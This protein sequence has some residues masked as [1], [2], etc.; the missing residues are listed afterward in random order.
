MMFFQDGYSNPL[1][2]S[3]N[4]IEFL[5]EPFDSGYILFWSLEDKPLGAYADMDMYMYMVRGIDIST[6]GYFRNDIGNYQV[7]PVD[8][9]A[10]LAV[11]SVVWIKPFGGTAPVWTHKKQLVRFPG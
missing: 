5:V 11:K 3:W 8:Q 4:P 2:E 9:P 10:R 7:I 1:Y 6:L